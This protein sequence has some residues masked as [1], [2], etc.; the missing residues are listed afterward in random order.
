M[1]PLRRIAALFALA[2]ALALGQQ[3]ALLHAL[4]HASERIAQT[5]DGKPQT[6]PCEQCGLAAHLD[7][8]ASAPLPLPA[9]TPASAQALPPQAHAAPSRPTVVYR[10]RA[11]P[12]LS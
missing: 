8:I 3:A 9:I 1:K 2:L 10:S 7:G 12:V 4:G 5:Q 6:A 11:P